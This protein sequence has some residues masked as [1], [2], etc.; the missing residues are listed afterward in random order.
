LPLLN[1]F[2]PSH[3]QVEFLSQGP[4]CLSGEMLAAAHL[5]T[6]RAMDALEKTGFSTLLMP[7][8]NPPYEVIRQE[9]FGHLVAWVCTFPFELKWDEDLHLR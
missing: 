9:S 1:N 7:G 3:L 2:T 6:S 8:P 4:G 5:K